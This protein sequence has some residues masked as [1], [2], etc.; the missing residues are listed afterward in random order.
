VPAEPESSPDPP[1][2]AGVTKR[3]DEVDDVDE[4]FDVDLLLEELVEVH[5]LENEVEDEVDV[6][7]ELANRE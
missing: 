4:N 6:V 3:S 2:A 5:E 7:V 1:V